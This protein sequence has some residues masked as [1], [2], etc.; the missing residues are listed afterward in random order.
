MTPARTAAQMVADIVAIDPTAAYGLRGSAD[1]QALCASPLYTSYRDAE[2]RVL[3]LRFSGGRFSAGY[4]RVSTLGQKEDGWSITDQAERIVAYHLRSGLAFRVYSDASLSGKLPPDDPDLIARMRD[5]SARR[6]EDAYRRV[7]LAEGMFPGERDAME[8]WLAGAVGLIRAGGHAA[9]MPV[10]SRDEMPLPPTHGGGGRGIR[11]FDYRPGLTEMTRAVSRGLV[12][13]LTLTDVSRLAR[14]FSL[15]ARLTDDL[16]AARVR[17][18]G[19][20]ENLD[21][22]QEG[23]GDAG[24]GGEIA[25]LVLT[26]VAEYELRRILVGALRGI[27]QALS[28]GTPIGVLPTWL[29]RTESG[30]AE[31]VEPLC[32]SVREIVRLYLEERI[33]PTAIATRL[34]EQPERF[35]PP[36]RDT[37]HPFRGAWEKNTVRNILNNCAIAGVQDAFGRLWPTLPPVVTGAEWARLR[38]ASSVRTQASGRKGRTSLLSRLLRCGCGQAMGLQ[39]RAGGEG[40]YYQC[41]NLTA[42]AH[43]GDIPHARIP[44]GEMDRFFSELAAGH[45]GTLLLLSGESGEERGALEASLARLKEERDALEAAEGAAQRAAREKAGRDLALLGREASPEMVAALAQ[46][47]AALLAAKAARSENAR[48]IAEVQDVLRT[49]LPAATASAATDLADSLRHWERMTV[50]ERNGLLRRLIYDVRCVVSADGSAMQVLVRENSL[51]RGS[52]PP[53]DALSTRYRNAGWARRMPHPETWLAGLAG[54]EA[55]PEAAPEGDAPLTS[56]APGT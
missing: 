56:P 51:S 52:L 29:R 8:R 47:D 23:G 27:Y 24:F 55:A 5:A 26:K 33:G 11:R 21:W 15:S 39:A 2:G 37:G 14:S 18:V 20:V 19:L 10:E 17:V 16:Q 42:R 31:R 45:A 9:G 7:F 12:H 53:I 3:P 34:N 22:M 28:S 43:R 6:Y 44:A 49:L 35:P 32:A 30:R 36:V 4:V 40:A 1:A 54:G 50:A 38:E 25:A 48:Q 13:T 41:L 46:G